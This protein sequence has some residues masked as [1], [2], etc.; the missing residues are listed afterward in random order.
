MR[1]VTFP[2][3]AGEMAKHGDTRTSLAEVLGTTY[4]R[5][6]RRLEGKTDW[7]LSEI[8]KICERYGRTCEELFKKAE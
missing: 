7:S 6:R 4:G 8:N 2:E 3:L 1:K 5:V